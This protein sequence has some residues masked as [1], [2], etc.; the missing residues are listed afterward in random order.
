MHPHAGE[1]SVVLPQDVAYSV[2]PL[3]ELVQQRLD[4]GIIGPLRYHIHVVEGEELELRTDEV[5]LAG[6]PRHDVGQLQT[7]PHLGGP[8]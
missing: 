5:I 3:V 2:E 8:V 1:L 7:V 4:L 6:L